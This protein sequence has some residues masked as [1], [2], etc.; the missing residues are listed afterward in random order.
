MPSIYMYICG[1]NAATHNN[2]YERVNDGLTFGLCLEIPF[3]LS[4]RFQHC[5]K[6][7]SE[8][9]IVVDLLCLRLF[10]WRCC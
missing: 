5:G 2:L 8:N 1:K 3:I 6:V 10:I 4:A 7:L 9:V